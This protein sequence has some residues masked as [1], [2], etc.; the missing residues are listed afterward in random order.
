MTG[1]QLRQGRKNKLWTQEE[2]AT[3]LGV[4]QPYLSLMES[5]ARRVPARFAR[6]AARLYELSSAVLPLETSWA[7][8][9]RWQAQALA[10]Y[11]A[12][13]GYPGLAYLKPAR[14]KKNPAEVLFAAL[15]CANLESRL[16]E[17]LPWVVLHY[18]DLD[19]SWLVT[20]AKTQNLQNRL[21]FVTAL[22]RRLVEQGGKGEVGA[23]LG[24]QEAVLDRARLVR[25]DTLC[26]H[27]LSEAE[28]RWVR[29]NRSAEARHWNLLTDLSPEHLSYAA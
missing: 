28:R 20:A 11:L 2:A 12:G 22:A 4:S 8:A 9:P 29:E 10:V 23:F 1:R 17:A 13:L 21:G 16:T 19:W 6:K 18:P 26:H 24:Q 15:N 7:E 25:E 5:G 27:S 3:K 14:K